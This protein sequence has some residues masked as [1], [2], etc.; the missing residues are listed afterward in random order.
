MYEFKKSPAEYGQPM[1]RGT[2]L[3]HP[4]FQL[5]I[6][7][8]PTCGE[9]GSLRTHSVDASGMVHPSI[10]CTGRILEKPCSFH[11]TGKLLDWKAP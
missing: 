11:E 10:V 5:P 8:C 3:V 6:L 9:L 7:C 2:W 4:D 1:E